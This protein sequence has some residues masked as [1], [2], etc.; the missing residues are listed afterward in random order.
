VKAPLAQDQSHYYLI[1]SSVGDLEK[2]LPSSLAK[3]SDVKG[4]M[5]ALWLNLLISPHSG[6]WV[7][8]N[9]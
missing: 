5:M 8:L 3:P 9:K 1:V 7:I 2:T 4:L 6:K